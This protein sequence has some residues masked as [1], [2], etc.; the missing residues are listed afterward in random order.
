MAA[1]SDCNREKG[2]RGAAM[3]NIGATFKKLSSGSFLMVQWLGLQA[4][5]AVAW[6]QSLVGKL[7]SHK[8]AHPLKKSAEQ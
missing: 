7:R 3:A 1:K 4:F 2:R 8:P 5:T 6:V